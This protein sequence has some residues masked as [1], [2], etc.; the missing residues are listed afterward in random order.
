MPFLNEPIKVDFGKEGN[1]ALLKFV[2]DQLQSLTQGLD[3][4]IILN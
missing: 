3:E 1:D 2:K 4:F